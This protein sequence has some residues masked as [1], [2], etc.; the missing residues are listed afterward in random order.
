MEVCFDRGRW[1]KNTRTA[2]SIAWND[3]TT[4][5]AA[6]D[7]ETLPTLA[8]T[9]ADYLIY[10]AKDHKTAGVSMHLAAIRAAHKMMKAQFPP[11][12]DDAKRFT[13]DMEHPVLADTWATI[14]RDNG[15]RQQPKAALTWDKLERIVPLMP[16]TFYG[17]R[18]KTMLLTAF[19]AA[20]R[21]SE[22]A[23][24]NRDDLTISPAGVIIMIRRS[25]T[26]Q[27]GQGHTLRIPR[28]PKGVCVVDHLEWWIARAEITDGALFI[29]ANRKRVDP[30]Y[31]GVIVKQAVELIGENKA[32]YSGHSTRRG[33]VTTAF[34]N[35][36]P[37][38]SIR[39]KSRHASMDML[40]KYRDAA[41]V[42]DS[43]ADRAVFGL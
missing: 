8:Q 40:L 4:W 7:A 26:D 19:G 22:L 16:D 15:T 36:A 34:E 32:I 28:N 39:D 31:Y 30:A 23:A 14:R 2:Y 20:L 27:S 33:F 3:F 35:G 37:P 9:L 21:R 41:Q 43:P 10:R 6:R 13:I 12:S 5:C 29:T 24:L 18:N 1:A 25:K 38:E 11:D 42:F 17:L